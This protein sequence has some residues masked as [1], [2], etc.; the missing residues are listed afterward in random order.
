MF[1][2]YSVVIGVIVGL[3]LGGRPG[4]LA[5]L[6][7]E[8]VWVAVAA[9][10]VQTVLFTPGVWEAV[11]ELVPPIYVAS[12]GVVLLV[13]LRNLRRAWALALVALGTAS[14]LA[15]ILANG[16]YMPVT[17]EALGIAEPTKTLY[18]GNSVLTAD[19]LLAPL[20]DRF[21]LPDWLPLATAFSVGDVLISVGIALVLIVAMRRSTEEPTPG[22]TRVSD[23]G[24]DRPITRNVLAR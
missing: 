6:R 11:G 22:Q 2:L 19:P 15:A 8:W 16:G 10:M 1:M 4:R 21:M 12:T 5:E 3:L 9:M 17:A 23:V 18:G 20:V 13:I 7:L 14:N 24:A